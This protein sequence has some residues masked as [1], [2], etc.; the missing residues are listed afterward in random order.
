MRVLGLTHL[1][2]N[3]FNPHLAPFNRH[4]FRAL[5]DRNPVRVIAPIPWTV[6]VRARWNGAAPLPADRRAE[7]DGLTVDH[8][9]FYFPPKI[10]Q[11]TYGPLFEKSVR[12]VFRQRVAE[13]RPDL[14]Y[15]TWAYPDGWAAVRLAR[16]AGLPV[17]VQVLG[18][19]VLVLTKHRDATATDVRRP[20]G[21]RRGGRGQPRPG[22]PGDRRRG[23]PGPGPGDLRRGRSGR[24]PPRLASSTPGCGS[25]S[26]RT[27][28]PVLLFIGRLVQGEGARR[29]D[30]RLF[31]LWPRPACRS[32]AGSS[33]QGP[34]A[35]PLQ[36]QID[37]LG[38]GDAGQAARPQAAGGAAGLV[39]GGRRVRPAE[40]LRG[41]AER[42]AGG[43]GVRP[44]VRRQP[45]R[46]RPGDQR[47]RRHPDGAARRPGRAG[48][49]PIREVL[50]GQGRPRSIAPPRTW[51]ET[52]DELEQFL[53]G[54][55]T[56]GRAVR[57]PSLVPV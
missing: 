29:P 18:S 21:G 17:V 35:G 43:D 39:P 40:P 20:P 47:P 37:R 45:G 23:G 24:V 1:Y 30:R 53:A 14:V 36:A 6:E 44:A 27:A 8:P 22:R 12:R 57:Q 48:R 3:P 4:L 46:R 54:V 19:D 11:W 7:L 42:P 2:P 38:L 55:L 5:G 32:S 15:A 49:A 52:V 28:T 41:R 50:T 10:L 13:F 26:P 33:A 56:T 25:G 31:D 9:R 34:L 16:R 51:T